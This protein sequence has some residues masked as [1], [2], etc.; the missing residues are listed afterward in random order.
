MAFSRSMKLERGDLR[1][2]NTSD[3]HGWAFLERGPE[4][5][6]RGLILSPDDLRWLC[7]TAGPALLNELAKGAK[8]GND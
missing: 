2:D 1:L 4:D 3:G 5:T 7:Q 6:A 8:D